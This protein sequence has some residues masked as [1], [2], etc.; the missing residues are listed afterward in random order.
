MDDNVDG[1]EKKRFRISDHDGVEWD[2]LIL[3]PKAVILRDDE[4]IIIRQTDTKG[5]KF[6]YKIDFK[7][8]RI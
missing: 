5:D 8:F 4:N 7:P 6:L 2:Q 1:K 3:D